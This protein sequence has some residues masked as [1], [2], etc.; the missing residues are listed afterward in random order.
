MSVRPALWA[1]CIC[2]SHQ[3]ILPPIPVHHYPAP[4]PAL[5]LTA[6]IPFSCSL[7]LPSAVLQLPT[8]HKPCFPLS[9]A[10]CI[11]AIHSMRVC[12]CAYICLCVCCGWQHLSLANVR[13]SRNSPL[14]VP[15]CQL[16]N[17]LNQ[18]Q[19]CYTTPSPHSPTTLGVYCYP[20]KY[21]LWV[22]ECGGNVDVKFL[23]IKCAWLKMETLKFTYTLYYV[24]VSL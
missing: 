3:H 23:A 9:V 18:H 24:R 19:P 22:P 6:D 2:Q 1:K 8:Q 11:A 14:A 20:H 4:T 10:H 13:C 7:Y 15:Q 17:G 5:T 21:M 12:V 16:S